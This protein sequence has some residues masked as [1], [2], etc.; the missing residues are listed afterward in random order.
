MLNK[1]ALIAFAVLL[2]TPVVASTAAQEPR[3]P[4]RVQKMLDDGYMV[5]YCKDNTCWDVV[6][7]RIVHLQDSVKNGYW[8]YEHGP[9]DERT[10]AS[11]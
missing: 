7:D 3:L 11:N 2:S 9:A 1:V 6:T 4:Y 8:T 5:A 10:A